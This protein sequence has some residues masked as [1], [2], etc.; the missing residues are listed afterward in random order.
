MARCFFIHP[1][2]GIP[3]IIIQMFIATKKNQ[4][5]VYNWIDDHGMTP[6]EIITT[7]KPLTFIETLREGLKCLAIVIVYQLLF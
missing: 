1:L 3:I 4:E 6:P 2:L 7:E 5:K